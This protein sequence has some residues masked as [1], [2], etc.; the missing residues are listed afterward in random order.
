MEIKKGKI[1]FRRGTIGDIPVLIDYRVRFL[2]ELYDHPEDDKTRILRKSLHEYF[3]KAIPSNDFIP[4]VSPSEPNSQS[5]IVAISHRNRERNS[6]V[7]SSLL[8]T[9]IDIGL[10][11]GNLR[12]SLHL[13]N[14]ID[15]VD[16]ALSVM[17][18]LD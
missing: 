18:S 3:A 9:G 6:E 10:R 13:Y 5:A 17:N 1:V 14:T 15:E 8:K 12:F 11:N 7:Y 2:N 4:W 16:R